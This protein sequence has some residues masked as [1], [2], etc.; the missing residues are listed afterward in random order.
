MIA[1]NGEKVNVADHIAEMVAAASSENTK[2][3]LACRAMRRDSPCILNGRV[4]E[5]PVS[6]ASMSRFARKAE[7]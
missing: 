2:M 5:V 1:W 6:A 7:S 4:P 3:A